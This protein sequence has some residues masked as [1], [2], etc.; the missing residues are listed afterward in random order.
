M[1]KLQ[2]SKRIKICKV[3]GK[4]GMP[5]ARGFPIAQV[6]KTL[7]KNYFLQY[8]LNKTVS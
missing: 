8:V 3:G 1:M 2:N 4:S 7:R 6:F 5:R